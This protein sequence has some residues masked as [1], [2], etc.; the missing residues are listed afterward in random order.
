VVVVVVVVVGGG[1]GGGG[2]IRES[3]QLSRFAA[4]IAVVVHRT[5]ACYIH[6]KQCL[7][8]WFVV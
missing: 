8:G 2:V 3:Q 1:G 5:S 7:G 6:N 4:Y